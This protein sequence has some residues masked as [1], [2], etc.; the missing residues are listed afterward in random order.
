M[1]L[2]SLLFQFNEISYLPPKKKLCIAIQN[3]FSFSFF[4]KDMIRFESNILHDDYLPSSQDT[5]RSFFF[6]F[7]FFVVV[8]EILYLMT[9]DFTC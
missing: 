1:F 3:L 2:V 7:L 6:L 8:D 9:K 5:N 4:I